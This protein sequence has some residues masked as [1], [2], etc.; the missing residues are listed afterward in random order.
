MPLDAQRYALT[1]MLLF[2]HCLLQVMYVQKL[3]ETESLV[4]LAANG[5]AS[6]MI[7]DSL[8]NLAKPSMPQAIAYATNIQ[9]VQP[10]YALEESIT[11]HTQ[12]INW[13]LMTDS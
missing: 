6:H 1:I 4:C 2:C 11:K 12:S 7:Q 8:R 13:L 10:T 3:I 9:T 5:Q